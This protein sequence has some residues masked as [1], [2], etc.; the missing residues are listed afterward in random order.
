[1]RGQTHTDK[2]A[3]NMVLLTEANATETISADKIIFLQFLTTQ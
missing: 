1:M 3:H 2:P